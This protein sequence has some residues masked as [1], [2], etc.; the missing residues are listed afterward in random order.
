[1]KLEVI[2]SKVQYIAR[3]LFG[4]HL[5]VD[6]GRLYFY[7]SGGSRVLPDPRLILRDC[8]ID[9]LQPLLGSTITDAILATQEC[10]VDLNEG[11]DCTKCVTMVFFRTAA[12]GAEIYALLG[13]EDG[14]KLR[15]KL[16]R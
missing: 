7:L 8:R 16:Y 3:E 2:S 5:E 13:L 4:A 12:E 6:N 15:D 1:M 14:A 10:Q 11:R 9:A